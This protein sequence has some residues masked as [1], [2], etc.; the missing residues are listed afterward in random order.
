[1]MDGGKLSVRDDLHGA[2]LDALADDYVEVYGSRKH[3]GG[4]DPCHSIV[5]V[6]TSP[7]FKLHFDFDIKRAI[8]AEIL[9]H[10]TVCDWIALCMTTVR[11]FYPTASDSNVF[12]AIVC[13]RES[14]ETTK[15]TDAFKNGHVSYGYHVVFPYLLTTAP[16]ALCIRE[17]CLSALYRE[18]GTMSL[19]QNSWKD[20]LDECVFLKNGLRM[21]L[22]HK[23]SPCIACKNV[24]KRKAQCMVCRGAGMIDGHRVYE[25]IA[26]LHQGATCAQLLDPLLKS[27]HLLVHRCSIRSFETQTRVPFVLYDGAPI[28]PV[29]FHEG[30]PKARIGCR[31]DER[32][33][34]RGGGGGH[35][36]NTN[37]GWTTLNDTHVAYSV[38][39]Q[40]IRTHMPKVYH[41][42]V[43]SKVQCKATQTQY[44]VLVEGEGSR[45]CQ[46]L[47]TGSCEHNSN[48]IYFLFTQKH[49]FQRCWCTCNKL[50]NRRQGLCSKFRSD[51]VPLTVEVQKMLFPS[52][53]QMK[54]GSFDEERNVT[55]SASRHQYLSS[56]TET[57][58]RLEKEQQQWHE[59]RELEKSRASVHRMDRQ[60]SGKKKSS[61]SKVKVTGTKRKAD[62]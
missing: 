17:A 37:C 1:M 55:L 14:I 57:I 35:A 30:T 4:T 8:H 42:V 12:D 43:V 29:I 22:S 11:K 13:A 7:M 3:I 28:L 58:E 24:A 19:V 52:S 15:A 21:V 25:P 18:Y 23:F 20:V 38:L 44:R 47:S 54:T 6:R 9:T 34:G 53:S 50:V 10:A 41:C 49:A 5:E 16:Q 2:F 62:E 33:G 56:L 46:N 51:P 36:G 31:E 26:Y 27:P 39:P 59:H 61:T 48:R 32:G 60:D 45:Y 40:F